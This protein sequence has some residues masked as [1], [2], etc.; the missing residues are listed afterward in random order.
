M[1]ALRATGYDALTQMDFGDPAQRNEDDALWVRVGGY[2]Y[3]PANLAAMQRT[4]G[5]L[6]MWTGA[7]DES[8]PPAYTADYSDAVRARYGSESGNFFQS[9]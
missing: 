1:K 3:D 4:G 8:I 2:G 6:I 9:F 5:K 7:S